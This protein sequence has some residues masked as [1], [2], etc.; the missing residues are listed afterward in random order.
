M[1]IRMKTVKY[2]FP[3]TTA[4]V[5]DATVTNLPQIT[6]NLPEAAKTFVSVT[7]ELGFYDVVTATGATINEHRLGLRLG[8]AAYTTITDL[9]DVANSGENFAALWGPYDFTSHFTTNWTGTTMTCD[10]QVYVDHT[11]GTTLGVNNVTLVLSITYEYDDAAATQIKTVHIPLESLVTQFPVTAANFGTNQ[12]PQLTGGGIL[13]E[14]NVTI[15][16]WFI[17]I[18]GNSQQT[19][20]TDIIV[21]ARINALT[22]TAFALI[23]GALATSVMGRL[24]YK[25][26]DGVP[27]TNAA[28]N[29]QLWNAGGTSAMHHV[30]VTLVVTYEFTL[31]GTTRIL[32]SIQTAMEIPTPLRSVTAANRSRFQREFIITEPGT[33]TLRQSAARMNYNLAAASGIF[34]AVGSQA[35]RS[36]TDLAVVAGG[37]LCL[38][39]RFDSGSAQGA[40]FTI[41][42]GSNVFTFDTY[43]TNATQDT[44]NV[45]GTIYL[46]YESDVPAQGIG[47][48]S[49]TVSRSLYNHDVL[50]NIDLLGFQSSSFQIPEAEYWLV[51]CSIMLYITQA[52]AA[53]GIVF[54]AERAAGEGPGAGWEGLYADMLQ[55]D[56]E[57][58]VSVIWIR[59]RDA[60]RRCP[61]DIDSK[62]MNL[63]T[64][65]NYRFFIVA[66]Q[67]ASGATW[68]VTY[69][70]MTF[71]AAG[72]ISGHDP[73]L[74]TTVRLVRADTQEAI[75]QQTLAAGVSA[76]SFVVHD[77]VL[78]YYI[79]A[80]QDATHVGRSALAKAV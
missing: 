51:A 44:T 18:E 68:Q 48:A 41:A 39:Q 71:T 4:T 13:P 23:E 50:P 63:E 67:I 25:P 79:D 53:T 54:S 62:R 45:N 80:Y 1:A 36:Y 64:V 72:N 69:H 5:A 73:A 61:G 9:D 26:A 29:L 21:N 10:A 32:N 46:N 24:V 20:T 75:K 66:N 28:H 34:V 55:T 38:Q 3:I 22:T 42:R 47:A 27:A 60:F 2:A 40:G 76:F 78:D 77:N 19:G 74:P 65:R 33:I 17:L 16:D 8:A 70:S 57:N 11:T 59:A 43:S 7:A 30:A 56:A 58:G 14:A 37:G 15:R 31:A 49:R 35:F 6:I 12:I 52:A